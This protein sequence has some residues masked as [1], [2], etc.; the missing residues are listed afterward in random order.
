MPGYNFTDRVR[1][2]LQ[3]ARE[4][5]A[6]LHH[7]YVGP[8]HILLGVIR[9]GEGVATRVL[10][11]LNVDLKALRQKI[12]DTVKP[13]AAGAAGPDL[14]YTSR[15]KRILELAMTEARELNHAYVGTE[16]LLLGVLREG[17]SAAAE[18]LIGAG[19]T[20]DK[21]RAETVRLLSTEPPAERER[22]DAEHLM[23]R[24]VRRAALLVRATELIEELLAK[25]MP[26]P[27]RVQGIAT[28]LKVLVEELAKLL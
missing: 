20:L 4:E 11:G 22:L 3:L 14:P 8:E 2:A 19:V 16:H 23:E 13:G 15:G 5:A 10:T 17:A 9:D 26:D 28:E 6:R 12:E 24:R 18:V 27:I 21:A 1:R 7:Q 25:P